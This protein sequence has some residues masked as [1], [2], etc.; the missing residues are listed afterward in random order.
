VGGGED[1][2]GDRASRDRAA[3]P[4]DRA[5]LE[6]AEQPGLGGEREVADLVEEQRPWWAASNR[7]WRGAFAPVNAPFSWPNS[8]ASSSDSVS[9]AQFTATNGPYRADIVVDRAG[10]GSL[11]VPVSP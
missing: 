3:D 4:P 11:P 1:A 8:S 6:H 9:V 7:P 5:L 2:D 10:D